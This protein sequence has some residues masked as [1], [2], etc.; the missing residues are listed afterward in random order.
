MFTFPVGLFSG[1]VAD[2]W[3]PAEITTALWLDAADAATITESSGSVSQWDDKSGNSRNAT[4]GTS[5]HRPVY[6]ATSWDGSLPSITFDGND[7]QLITTYTLANQHTIAY[8]AERGTQTGT[9]SILRPVIESASTSGNF[10]SYGSQR[11]TNTVVEFAINATRITVV[12]ASWTVGQKTTVSGTYNGTTLTGWQ[13]GNSYGSVSETTSTFHAVHIG[14]SGN[15]I[16][17]ERRF[18]GKISEVVIVG[19]VLSTNDRQK[20]E[21]YMAHKWGLTGGLPG[22]HPYKTMAP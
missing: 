4:Q 8:V 10:V 14:G 13:N 17:P 2:P 6:S 21:G 16:F 22:G 3:T 5:G 15:T 12:S 7:D 11:G 9:G 1:A 20:L 19:S 18:A